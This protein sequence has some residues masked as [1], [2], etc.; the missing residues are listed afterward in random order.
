MAKRKTNAG[1][2]N[3][4]AR[5]DY[6]LGDEFTVGLELSGVEV[7]SLRLN[8]GQLAGAYITDKNDELWLINA[9]I[10]PSPGLPISEQDQ[11]RSRKILAKR[12]EI[13]KMIAA[14]ADGNTIV[15]LELLTKGRYIKLKIAIG[16]GKRKYDKRETIKKREQQ[17]D[18]ARQSR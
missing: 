4:R 18:I 14:R 15:P 12:S 7:K 9:Q 8:H 3:R 1:I 16:R 11:T 5:F 10:M 17:R 6:A 13:N 2:F